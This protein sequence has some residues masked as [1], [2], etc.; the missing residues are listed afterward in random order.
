M[1]VGRKPRQGRG[2]TFASVATTGTTSF[3]GALLPQ[4]FVDRRLLVGAIVLPWRVLVGPRLLTLVGLVMTDH[5]PG[6]RADLSMP[7]HVPGNTTDDRALDAALGVRRDRRAH[8]SNQCGEQYQS[9]H[10]H[11]SSGRR[12][13][14]PLRSTGL[15]KFRLKLGA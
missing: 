14:Q 13:K 10:H 9:F 6:E 7:G 1:A 11:L 5:T 15:W 4:A 3:A 2:V 8:G 12:G